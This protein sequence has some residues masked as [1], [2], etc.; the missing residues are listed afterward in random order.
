NLKPA[1]FEQRARRNVAKRLRKCRLAR[2]ITQTTLAR[3]VGVTYQQIQKYETGRDRLSIE[4]LMLIAEVLDVPV[5]RLLFGTSR[6]SPPPVELSQRLTLTC[7][8]LESL[9][10]YHG[11]IVIDGSGFLAACSVD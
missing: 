9:G 8:G 10:L 3:R 2:K 4:R 6:R 5:E 7:N 1:A 11:D